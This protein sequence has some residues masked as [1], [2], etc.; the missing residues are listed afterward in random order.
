M[1]T[2]SEILRAIRSRYYLNKIA[3]KGKCTGFD[4]ICRLVGGKYISIGNY[5]GF[6]HDLTL[7][8]WD[9]YVSQLEE[10]TFHPQITIGNYCNFGAFNHISACNNITIGDGLLTGKWVTIVDN[11]HGDTD[12]D[13]MA[14]SPIKRKLIS[15]GP[16]IIGNN[17][18]IGDKATIL[19]GVTIGD[20]AIIAA[21]AV[22]TKDVPAFSVVAGNPARIVKQHI[23]HKVSQ[24]E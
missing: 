3:L 21:N 19:P 9:H 2:I 6:S 24:V 8:A 5:T 11:S 7:T 15:K 20:G 22:V 4:H 23:Q 12:Y 14:I 16:V 10:Q 13:S 1:K 17:V 18:W